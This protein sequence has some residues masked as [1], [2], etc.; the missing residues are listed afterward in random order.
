MTD[1]HETSI[2]WDSFDEMIENEEQ[3]T[4]ISW[5]HFDIFFYKPSLKGIPLIRQHNE[6]QQ[7]YANFKTAQFVKYIGSFLMDLHK[8]L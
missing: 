8:T 1:F 5:L 2:T 6:R 3:Q 4:L 7:P